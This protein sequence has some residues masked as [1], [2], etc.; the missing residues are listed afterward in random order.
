MGCGS[1]KDPKIGVADSIKPVENYK[2]SQNNYYSN[3][4]GSHRNGFKHVELKSSEDPYLKKQ[5]NKPDEKSKLN[6]EKN[7]DL[8]I[9]WYEKAANNGHEEA[10]EKLKKLTKPKKVKKEVQA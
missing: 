1:S 6:F 7:L 8:A 10:K 5:N 4:N 9:D 2:S 3:T